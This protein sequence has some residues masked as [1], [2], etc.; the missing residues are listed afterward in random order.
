MDPTDKVKTNSYADY[1]CSFQAYS[2]YANAKGILNRLHIFAITT[3]TFTMYQSGCLLLK[4]N[5][6]FNMFRKVIPLTALG[7]MSTCANIKALEVYSYQKNDR[8]KK[9]EK[10]A[11]LEHEELYPLLYKCED[12]TQKE[13]DAQVFRKEYQAYRS[14]L[15][16]EQSIQYLTLVAGVISG[17]K[18]G[19][20]M[21][22]KF[23]PFAGLLCFGTASAVA[24]IACLS[25]PR[26]DPDLNAL[27]GRHVEVNFPEE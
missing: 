4:A 21:T 22:R 11:N 14:T 10:I 26:S 27:L 6:T 25:Y 16:K 19:A 5:H 20:Y 18:M 17:V 2:A 12:W 7:F 23:N 15:M 13:E 1:N 8:V 9:G 3:L 24:Q